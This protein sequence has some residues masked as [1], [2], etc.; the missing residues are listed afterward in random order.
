METE[1]LQERY[2]QSARVTWIGAFCNLLLAAIKCLAGWLGNSHA[3]FADGVHSLSDLFADGIVLLA[4]KFGNEAADTEH[5]YGHHRI[6]TAATIAV[7]LFLLAAG[8][9]IIM[10]GV[11]HMLHPVHDT[12]IHPYVLWI[13]ILALIVNE[14]IYWMTIRVARKIQSDM[15]AA[16]AWHRRS[17][18]IVSLIVLIGIGASML[19]FHYLDG[20][21]AIVVGLFILKMAWSMGRKSFDE[22][23][24]RGLSQ[25]ELE[26]IKHTIQTVPGVVGLHMLRT[27]LSGGAIMADVHVMVEPFFSVSE[28]H[29]VG[30]KVYALLKEKYPAI[31]DITVHVDSENDELVHDN[32]SLP[33]RQSISEI[34]ASLKNELPLYSQMQLKAIHYQGTKVIL[35]IVLPLSALKE[36]AAE[37]FANAYT[38]A[39]QNKL[40]NAQ[41]QL[42]YV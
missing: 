12:Y 22:L 40:S 6:E 1:D 24:D 19:G 41:V 21:A 39:I 36:R 33:S 14:S 30:E 13:A 3:L 23:V 35:E 10:D 4:S 16:H 18:A 11:D 9:G 17:D 2:R 5:P 32:L 29:Y 15:L 28:G 37:N 31:K 7:A 38:V 27:R 34:L 25:K 8:V 20:I 26:D 42:F